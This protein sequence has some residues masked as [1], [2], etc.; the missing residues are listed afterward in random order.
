[1][2]SNSALLDSHTDKG[3]TT[4]CFLNFF[5]SLFGT[6]ILSLPRAFA[7]GGLWGGLG[8]FFVATCLC[9]SS[10]LLT[11]E[12]QRLASRQAPVSFKVDTFQRVTHVAF[13]KVGY[14]LT[15]IIVVVLELAFC[16][17]WIIVAADQLHI[18]SGMDKNQ[19]V[20][21]LCPFLCVLVCIRF[22][23]DLWIFSFLGLLT[24]IFGVMGGLYFFI[25]S[26]D[27]T[28]DA[29]AFSPEWPKFL[30][31]ALYSMEAILMTI[32]TQSCMARPEHADWVVGVAV[33]LFAVLACAFGA[34]GVGLQ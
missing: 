31:V 33:V 29:E 26:G 16:T 8:L 23:K 25:V 18:V 3:S 17:G 14:Y 24:Y 20:W 27:R 28:P 9:T 4:V 2:E 32:P 13:G 19:L 11:L 7:W 10:L 21:I 22:L 15:L 1:M 34:S 30:G 5:K 6:G 12:C